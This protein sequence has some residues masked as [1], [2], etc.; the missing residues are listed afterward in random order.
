M[1]L[2]ALNEYARRHNLV[3]SIELT[4]RP[5]HLLLNLRTDGSVSPG[6]PWL[7]LQSP[8]PKDK[9]GEKR[10]LGATMMMPR[11]PG[12]N[13]GGKAHFLADGCGPVL[14][15]DPKTGLPLPDDPKV[16]KNATKS[17]LHFWRRIEEARAAIE[18]PAL[19]AILAFRDRHL[20]NAKLREGLEF[21]DSRP[22]GKSGTPTFCALTASD[23]IPLEGKTIGFAL[24]DIPVFEPDSPL[25]LYWSSA[26]R[27]AAFPDRSVDG[28]GLGLCLVTG[29]RDQ[30]IA[31]S[32]TPEI[33]GVRGLPPKGGYLVSF[34]REAPA[35]A[36][37]GFEGSWNA[38]VSEQAVAGY[39]LA[40]NALLRDSRTARPIGDSMLCSWLRERPEEAEMVFDLLN[41]PSPDDVPKF[42][43]SFK[44]GQPRHGLRSD[45]YYSLSLASN[46]GRVVVRRWL[47]V[48]LGEVVD[49]LKLWFDD[50]SIDPID[51]P[52]PSTKGKGKAPGDGAD[53]A[54]SPPYRSVLALAWAT[55]RTPGDVQPGVYDSLYRAALEGASVDSLLAPAVHRIRI[56]AIQSGANVR[57][58]MS[59]FALVKMILKRL[60]RSEGSTMTIEHQ[61]CEV[62]DAPYN[63]GRLLAVLDDIQSRAQGKLGADIIA[64]FYGNASSFPGNSFPRLLRLARA[65]L[66]KLSKDGDT[67]AAGS[68][69]Q[70]KL[71]DIC[72]LFPPGQ[73]GVPEFPGQL[74]IR[75]QGRFALGFYQQKAKD[76]R[77]RDAYKA[78]KLAKDQA[79]V[80]DPDDE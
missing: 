54:K 48:A 19:D 76:Q 77:D 42:L 69:L 50:L 11:F 10:V 23:P 14:G 62:L 75:E 32:H 8:D 70:G 35:L 53:R 21:V 79:A 22:I 56:A 59:R 58:Q 63:C 45:R 41:N 31:G 74:N 28:E 73:S 4:N 37:Y 29:L 18:S 3:E 46:G 67:I 7:P 20:A 65:H 49:H 57:Y 68:A 44:T 17:F 55:A 13:T 80:P 30:P 39:A 36:S 24:E 2:Q 47:D 34:A 52:T 43:D 51:R 6:A 60:E 61:L 5:I 15:I 26:Y 25:H 27:I 33:K 1:L 66:N 9:K 72:S 16:G 64:R 78:A 40:L 71:F 38:P 12:G